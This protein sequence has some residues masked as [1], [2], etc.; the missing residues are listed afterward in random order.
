LPSQDKKNEIF[1]IHFLATLEVLVLCACSLY[2]TNFFA[3][4]ARPYG[5]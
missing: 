3:P 4:I 5:S 2:Y 1:E